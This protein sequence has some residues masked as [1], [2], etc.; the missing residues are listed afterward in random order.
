MTRAG[1]VALS[2]TLASLSSVEQWLYRGLSTA[3][4]EAGLSVE[5]WRL[6]NLVKALEAPTMGELAAA[7]ALPGASL[8][9]TVDALED[10]A[11]VF[12][13]VDQDDRRRITVRLSDRGASRLAVAQGDRRRMGREPETSSRRGCR[14]ETLGADRDDGGAAHRALS[15]SA[16]VVGDAGL[17]LMTSSV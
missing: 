12:R 5:Q 8:S 3:L 17:E 4:G 10:D 11:S 2:D 7:S 13:L 9:R 15:R 16:G 1:A 6:L 14:R